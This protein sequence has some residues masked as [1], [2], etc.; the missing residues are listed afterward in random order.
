MIFTSN[1]TAFLSPSKP[2]YCKALLP[3]STAVTA[4]KKKKNHFNTQTNIHMYIYISQNQKIPN[5]R[6]RKKDKNQ[7]FA[8]RYLEQP[9]NNFPIHKTIIHSKNM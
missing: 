8:G 7:T 2:R 5:S 6:K 3:L 9:L 4:K 1:P